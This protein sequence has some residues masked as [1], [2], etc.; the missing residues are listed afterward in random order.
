M[1]ARMPLAAKVEMASIIIPQPCHAA[2]GPNEEWAINPIKQ[3]PAVDEFNEE[4][5]G[6]ARILALSS[7]IGKNLA[8]AAAMTVR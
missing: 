4:K 8:S 1:R 5:C 2:S 7:Q 6:S 3:L